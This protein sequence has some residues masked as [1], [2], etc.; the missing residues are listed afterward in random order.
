LI[1]NSTNFDKNAMSSLIDAM[2]HLYSG[3]QGIKGGN[4]LVLSLKYTVKEK[5]NE[6]INRLHDLLII[7]IESSNAKEQQYN[8]D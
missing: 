4:P 8:S 1:L 2:S 5:K 3:F 6:V 7:S